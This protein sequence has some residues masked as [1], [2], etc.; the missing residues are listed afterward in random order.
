MSP[1]IP[2]VDIRTEEGACPELPPD[3]T[4]R[5]GGAGRQDACGLVGEAGAHSRT[6]AIISGEEQLNGLPMTT[7]QVRYLRLIEAPRP[8]VDL[9]R[10]TTSATPLP[11]V[12]VGSE[13]PGRSP[14]GWT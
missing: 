9:R 2:L 7:V 5:L 14:V 10:F 3:E 11:T 1:Y 6:S 8:G 12:V 13:V 4:R